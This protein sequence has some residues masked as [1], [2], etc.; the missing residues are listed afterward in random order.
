[1]KVLYLAPLSDGTGYSHAAHDHIRSL[2]GAG[3]DVVSRD[4]KL[5]SFTDSMPKEVLATLN[6]N[7]DGITHTVQHILP[8]AFEWNNKAK[9]IGCFAYETDNIKPMGW[10]LYCNYMDAITVFSEENVGMCKTSGVKSSITRIPQAADITKYQ[11]PGDTS[12]DVNP[13]NRYMFYCI[14]DWSYRKNLEQLVRAYLDEFDYNDNVVLVLKTYCSGK[15]LE[16]SADYITKE[17]KAI[18]E[19]LRKTANNYW[20]PIVVVCNRITEAQILGLHQQGNCYVSPEMGSGWCIPAFEALAMGN[21]VI[22]S[23]R[24]GHIDFCKERNDLFLP[25]STEIENCYG[26]DND[27]APYRELYSSHQKWYRPSYNGLKKNMRT[28]YQNNKP[29]IKNMEWLEKYSYINVGKMWK[30]FLDMI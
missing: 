6:G 3:I 17:I 5:S 23:D 2:L 28:A 27:S 14:A 10:H 22:S 19:K 21:T 18:K 11:Q 1:M 20:P 13:D 29:K 26:M 15:T 9:H 24:G 8:Y 25:V 16:Q 7:L 12:L 30:E 4:V